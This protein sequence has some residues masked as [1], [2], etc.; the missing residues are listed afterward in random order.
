M[1]TLNKIFRGLNWQGVAALTVLTTSGTL[2]ALFGSGEA[3][4]AIKY[5][6]IGAAGGTLLPNPL[7]GTRQQGGEGE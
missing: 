4:E 3:L 6:C 1:T 7:R 2:I 5:I